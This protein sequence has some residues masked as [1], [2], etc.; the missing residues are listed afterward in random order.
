MMSTSPPITESLLLRCVSGAVPGRGEKPKRFFT[1]VSHYNL[2]N[3]NLTSLDGIE[4]A[5]GSR[6]LYLYD[7]H[8][9]SLAPLSRLRTL[10]QLYI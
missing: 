5:S 8:I 4:L 7:N 6:V 2:Q 10:G 1:R 3:R 9:S